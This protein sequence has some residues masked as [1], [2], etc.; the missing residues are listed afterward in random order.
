MMR[1]LYLLVLLALFVA[2]C[3]S[4]VPVNNRDN[5]AYLYGKGGSQMLLQARV[6]HISP[7]RSRVY[8]KLNTREILY[9]SNGTGGP[10]HASVRISYESYDAYGGKVLLDSASTLIDDE[11][12]DP[13]EERELI[14]SMDLRRKEQQPFIL[15]V[16]ARDLNRDLETTVYVRVEKDG[17][18]IRQYFMPV[19]T[20][21]GLPLFTDHFKGG[22]IKVRCEVCSGQELRGAHHPIGTTLPAPVFTSGSTLEALESS[23]DS[24]F[25]IQ[26]DSEGEFTLDLSRPGTYH[27]LPDTAQRA[28]YTLFSVD[29]AYPFVSTATDMLKPMR[30]I[31]SNQEFERIT[32]AT[33]VRRSIEKFWV[34]AAGDRERAREAIRIYYGRVENANRHFTAEVEGWRTDRGLV[35]IIFGTPT[36]IYRTDAQETWIYGEENNLMSLTF[37]FKR[38]KTPYSDNDLVLQRDPLLKGAWYRNVESWRNGRVYQ[39]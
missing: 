35:H 7:E 14:G 30:Y 11:S 37:T 20:A 2:G 19:D 10:F 17:M 28:G 3:G 31:T 29:D 6:H 38:R 22:V 24:T 26:V 36:S 1:T 25:L 33:D 9:K 15:K 18:G 32:N 8:Y 39:N 21:Y 27:L 12:I 23:V 13:T 16:M 5:L 34:D 4:A